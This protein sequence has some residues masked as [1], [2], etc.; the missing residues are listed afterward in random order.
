MFERFVEEFYPDDTYMLDWDLDE[1]ELVENVD[2]GCR[3]GD[4]KEDD[5]FWEF[6]EACQSSPPNDDDDDDDDDW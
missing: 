4:S 6:L 5:A 3:I 2:G 1:D